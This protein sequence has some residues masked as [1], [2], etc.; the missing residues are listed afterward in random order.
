M[1][2][3]TNARLT[4]LDHETC[5][6]GPVDEDDIELQVGRPRTTRSSALKRFSLA[7]IAGLALVTILNLLGSAIHQG[8]RHRY[9]HWGQWHGYASGTF[10]SLTSSPSVCDL[11]DVIQ[12][13]EEGPITH[14]HDEGTIW[15]TSNITFPL[16]LT[17]Q[18]WLNVKTGHTTIIFSHS[19]ISTLDCSN[20]N[21]E[22]AE[23]EK[24]SEM[25][26][27]ITLES[28]WSERRD[29]ITLMQ[30]LLSTKLDVEVSQM[31][32]EISLSENR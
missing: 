9:R 3:T 5:S 1:T 11:A 15:Q 30:G 7:L 16:D 2:A 25:K 17:K 10:V 32:C 12:R 28:T 14:L 29:T 23:L 18:L 20:Q 19:N 22:V 31:E 8:H 4:S 27:S 21:D 26:G 24:G 13:G 6:C